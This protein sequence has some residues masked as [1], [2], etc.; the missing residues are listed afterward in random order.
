MSKNEE[1]SAVQVK[2]E[3]QGG[4]ISRLT[5]ELKNTRTVQEETTKER[6]NLKVC[7]RDFIRRTR[8]G[9]Y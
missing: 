4:E 7:T 3:K 8:K 9:S 5:Q 6:D 2:L 1:L